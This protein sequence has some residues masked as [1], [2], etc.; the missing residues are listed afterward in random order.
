M[1][2]AIHIDWGFV[3]FTILVFGGS[4]GALLC[5]RHMI[6]EGDESHKKQKHSEKEEERHSNQ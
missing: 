6:H 3:L 2:M 5:F 4:A 1:P